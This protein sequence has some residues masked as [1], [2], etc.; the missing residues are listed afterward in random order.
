VQI[1]CLISKF[2]WDSGDPAAVPVHGLLGT[3][4]CKQQHVHREVFN[5]RV[6]ITC[7]ISKFFWDSGDPT[8][9]GGFIQ[10]TQQIP[11]QAVQWRCSWIDIFVSTNVHQFLPHLPLKSSTSCLFSL[12]KA[13][14]AINPVVIPATSITPASG[15]FQQDSSQMF[16]WIHLPAGLFCFGEIISHLCNPFLAKAQNDINPVVIPATSITP[17]SGLFQQDSS[18]MF[19]WIHLPAGLFCFGEIISH[20]CNPFILFLLFLLFMG[21]SKPRKTIKV[22]IKIERV[23]S[24]EGKEEEEEEGGG[25]EGEEEEKEEEEKEGVEEEEESQCI[26]VTLSVSI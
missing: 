26:T 17:A 5:Y 21:P 16:Q 7:L 20:L 24:A 4:Y 8:E 9:D 25:G 19:Q 13:Q 10:T 18:Q 23:E 3:G 12:A 22:T 1:T 2:F 15:L 6:Q 14:N 11:S